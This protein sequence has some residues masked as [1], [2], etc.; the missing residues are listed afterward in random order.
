MEG[1][2][3]EEQEAFRTKK[4]QIVEAMEELNLPN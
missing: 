3:R 4:L 1:A 2:L